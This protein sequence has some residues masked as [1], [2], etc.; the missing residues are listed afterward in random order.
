VDDSVHAL[1]S[2]NE[3]QI[4]HSVSKA[5]DT[6]RLQTDRGDCQEHQWRSH[7]IRRY[8]TPE[9]LTSSGCNE[10]SKVQVTAFDRPPVPTEPAALA[11]LSPFTGHSFPERL[12]A[13]VLD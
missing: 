1:Q 6:R 3:Y 8:G 7:S 11:R 9:S 13:Q 5:A 2:P 12:P 4:K 10:R